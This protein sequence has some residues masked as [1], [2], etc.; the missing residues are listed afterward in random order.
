MV[1]V[2]YLEVVSCESDVG[3]WSVIVVACDGC[4]VDNS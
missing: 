4:L 3:L 2:S 1:S